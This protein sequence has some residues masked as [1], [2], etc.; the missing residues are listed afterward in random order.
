M[1]E[2][3]VGNFYSQ[4]FTSSSPSDGGIEDVLQHVKA[5]ISS[6]KNE[7]LMRPY[8]KD[9][10]FAALQQMHPCKAPGPNGMHAIFYQKFWHIIGDDVYKFV[11]SILCGISTLEHVNNTNI[12]LIPKVKSPVNMSEF[13]PIS[14]CNVL[15]KL[16]S[17]VIVLRLK[18]ILPK[19]V[20]EN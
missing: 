16:V 19:V 12:A 11:R 14:L 18:S 3:I 8:T 5:V 6:E 17:K 1:F 15:Y 7:E 4:L 2:G 10:V 9:E 13:R 20:T